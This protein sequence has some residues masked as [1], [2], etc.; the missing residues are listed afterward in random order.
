MRREWDGMKSS[1]KSESISFQLYIHVYNNHNVKCISYSE[2]RLKKCWKDTNLIEGHIEDW[3]YHRIS[4]VSIREDP[5][6]RGRLQGKSGEPGAYEEWQSSW[7]WICTVFWRSEPARLN[8]SWGKMLEGDLGSAK[9]FH[10]SELSNSRWECM[11][12]EWDACIPR[13]IQVLVS[14]L[15]KSNS[16][17]SLPTNWVLLLGT[18]SYQST[19][20]PNCK[21]Q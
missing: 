3:Y 11:T 18:C 17:R 1:W 13:S 7:R 5:L 15:K 16:L 19:Q 10:W 8:Y 14:V 20:L 6:R 21:I 12:R 4:P 2:L 9:T